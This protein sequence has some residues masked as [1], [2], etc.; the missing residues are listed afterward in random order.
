MV[1]YVYFQKKPIP[2]A[3]VHIPS[4]LPGLT[5]KPTKP[6]PSN[7]KAPPPMKPVIIKTN[8]K[9]NPLNR[10]KASITAVKVPIQNKMLFKNNAK[11]VPSPN[12]AITINPI[13]SIA[14]N[15][16]KTQVVL[17]KVV[18][19]KR[20]RTAVEIKRPNVLTGLPPS[21]TIKPVS[22]GVT[23]KP[24]QQLKI[25]PGSVVTL[26]KRRIGPKRKEQSEVLTVELDDDDTPES[27]TASP[28]WYL[29][30]EEQSKKEAP[31]KK[32]KE[33]KDKNK[34]EPSMQVDSTEPSM[35]EKNN[36][37]P[38][39]TKYFEI[40]IEDSPLKPIQRHPDIGNI[41]YF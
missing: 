8:L 33:A 7:N 6:T 3:M 29:R 13:P 1:P 18:P 34:D 26:K 11:I 5:I 39:T 31:L 35:E 37:E 19:L 4:K 16:S 10:S 30:P 25:A 40:T 12:K 2:N 20:P 15:L 38:D 23:F 17:K 28:Q 22:T 36:K 27:A 21:V 9:V 41:L 24:V 14:Q 32:P